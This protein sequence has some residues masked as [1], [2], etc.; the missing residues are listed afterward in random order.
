MFEVCGVADGFRQ[1][2]R[3]YHEFVNAYKDIDVI[4]EFV[5]KL[6]CRIPPLSLVPHFCMASIA[7]G[8]LKHYTAS[9]CAV[10]EQREGIKKELSKY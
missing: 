8:C 3:S 7:Y 5:H 4:S 9:V 1:I 6:N 2:R 10:L